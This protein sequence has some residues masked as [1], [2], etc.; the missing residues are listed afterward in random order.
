[1]KFFCSG[2]PRA[3]S[4]NIELIRDKDKHILHYGVSCLES[5]KYVP[6]LLKGFCPIESTPKRNNISYRGYL[7]SLLA[8]EI[9]EAIKPYYHLPKGVHVDSARIL[10][11]NESGLITIAS[12][13]KHE[14]RSYRQGTAESPVSC[15]LDPESLTKEELEYLEKMSDKK[16]FTVYKTSIGEFLMLKWSENAHLTS[17]KETIEARRHKLR[18]AL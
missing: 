5:T 9:L 7:D 15:W 16:P 17:P 1:M 13:E 11:R 14:S 6:D 10:Q 12:S 3:K 4:F 2:E 18:N 8:R